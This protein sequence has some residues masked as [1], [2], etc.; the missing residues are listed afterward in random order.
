MCFSPKGDR[1]GT[2]LVHFLFLGPGLC[3]RAVLLL[4][5]YYFLQNVVKTMDFR[6]ILRQFLFAAYDQ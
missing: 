6:S 5:L 1:S 4:L 3:T 2:G